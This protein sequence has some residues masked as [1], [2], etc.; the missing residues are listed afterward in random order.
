[1]L[2]FLGSRNSPFDILQGCNLLSNYILQCI[3]LPVRTFYSSALVGSRFYV[4]F[5]YPF[6]LLI[7]RQKEVLSQRLGECSNHR[8]SGRVWKERKSQFPNLIS[9][10]CA[11]GWDDG[12]KSQASETLKKLFTTFEHR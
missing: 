11:E 8:I 1:M 3:F 7:L 4:N 9:I 6:I 5:A 10:I 12:E 2:Y